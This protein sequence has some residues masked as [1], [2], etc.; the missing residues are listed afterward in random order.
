VSIEEDWDQLKA[1]VSFRY[2]SSDDVMCENL[3]KKCKK[4]AFD[5]FVEEEEIVVEK[6]NL[7][8]CFVGTER[9]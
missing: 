8:H 1:G 6:V 2:V 7:Q 9:H 4:T 5:M 3:R